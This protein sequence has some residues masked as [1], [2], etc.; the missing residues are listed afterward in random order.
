VQAGEEETDI[1]NQ[2]G[3]P[4]KK[5]PHSKPLQG[6]TVNGGTNCLLTGGILPL[7]RSSVTGDHG[8]DK[9]GKES[10]WQKGETTILARQRTAHDGK[11]E[12]VTVNASYRPIPKE[13][14]ERR[15]RE[16]STCN[17]TWSAEEKRD[18]VP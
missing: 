9:K 4:V 13:G 11:K 3:F 15:R 7:H 17:Q 8:E 5:R 10:L 1:S 6:S 16:S 14:V 12:E 2:G 18:M